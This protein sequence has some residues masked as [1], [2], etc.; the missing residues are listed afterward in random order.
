MRTEASEISITS[1]QFFCKCFVSTLK[2]NLPSIGETLFS[3]SMSSDVIAVAS[4]K[5]V[6]VDSELIEDVVGSL[7]TE[8]EKISHSDL[9]FFELPIRENLKLEKLRFFRK[10][11]VRKMMIYDRNMQKCMIFI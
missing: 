10:N 1:K 5:V 8:K 3:F 6:T 11:S 2:E 4:G 9:S 7:E